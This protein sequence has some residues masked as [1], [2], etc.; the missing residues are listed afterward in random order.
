MALVA[1]HPRPQIA[2]D[3]GRNVTRNFNPHRNRN[4]FPP[5]IQ[6]AAGLNPL[7]F[8]N[9]KPNPPLFTGDLNSSNRK[10]AGRNRRIRA[11][12]RPQIAESPATRP[13]RHWWPL[14]RIFFFSPGLGPKSRRFSSRRPQ[15][16]LW[17]GQL[18]DDESQGRA[19]HEVI[20]VQKLADN[21][22]KHLWRAMFDPFLG[23][24][25]VSGQCLYLRAALQGTNLRG[26]TPICGFGGFSVKILRKLAVSCENLRFPNAL[27]FRK[28]R[29]SAKI[30]E[31]QWKSAFGLG[32]S[33]RFVPLSA[34]WYLVGRTRRGL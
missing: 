12:K 28:R 34:P 11:A 31:N 24:F 15:K 16:D 26:Q 25:C 32:L 29:E 20:D 13:L 8:E 22:P 18:H 27:F 17:E 2:S 7:R 3:L 14:C 4:Q 21:R 1:F 6:I 19:N 23:H 9:R 5:Q 30:S 10:P 33:L